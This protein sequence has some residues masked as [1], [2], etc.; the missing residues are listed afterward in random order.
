[1]K[2]IFNLQLLV[3][4]IVICNHTYLHAQQ[5]NKSNESTFKK[6]A[7]ETSVMSSLI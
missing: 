5:G 3:I 4:A 2:R 1:M 7:L 6:H